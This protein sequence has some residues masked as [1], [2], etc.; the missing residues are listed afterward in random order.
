MNVQYLII[1]GIGAMLLL[2]ISLLLAFNTSQ[3]K[4]FQYQQ[5]VQHLKEEQQNE[6]IK[7]AV[8]SE[9]MERHRISE[10]LHDEVGA[11]LSATKLY[12]GNL[13]AE[14]FAG[15]DASVYHKSL[16]LLDDSIQKVRSISHNLHSGILKELG[17]NEALHSFTQ[18]LGQAGGLE[19]VTDLDPNYNSK[20]PESDIS[21]YRI[22][23]ELFNNIIKH[24][25][26]TSIR[27]SS[28]IHGGH[29]Q[30]VIEHNGKGLTQEEFERLRYE[31]R[32]LGLKTIQNRIILLKGKINFEKSGDQNVITL[33][34]P[35]SA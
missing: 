25:K 17:L 11:L 29:L 5:N 24:S 23:Q 18:K 21:I 2:I 35:V 13:H 9:E 7:A 31:A 28:R 8:R 33:N 26:A 22:L 15:D 20:N 10:E 14:K 6:L 30:F 3:R 4:K 27:I 19:I 1:I 12:L 32:G 16:E 34:T